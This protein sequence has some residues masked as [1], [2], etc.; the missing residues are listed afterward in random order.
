MQ[1]QIDKLDNH[2]RMSTANLRY[3]ANPS[4]TPCLAPVLMGSATFETAN[5]SCDNLTPSITRIDSSRRLLKRRAKE[6]H[7]VSSCWG[8]LSLYPVLPAAGKAPGPPRDPIESDQWRLR[9]V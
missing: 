2:V 9:L 4:P 8:A 5:K 1:G 3:T 7:R 6:L